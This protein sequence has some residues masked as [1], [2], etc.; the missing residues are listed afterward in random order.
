[1]HLALMWS[2]D[3]DWMVQSYLDTMITDVSNVWMRLIFDCWQSNFLC[4]GWWSYVLLGIVS[5]HFMFNI[6]VFRIL[7]RSG[8]RFLPV[9]SPLSFIDFL[10]YFISLYIYIV[11]HKFLTFSYPSFLHM[12]CTIFQ[13]IWIV[14]IRSKL[15]ILKIKERVD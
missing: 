6:D 2:L 5:D 13:L 8:L 7:Q 4:A 3:W 10:N 11:V 1:M 14:V 9:L 12:C 15:K